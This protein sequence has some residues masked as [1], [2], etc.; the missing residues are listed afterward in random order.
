MRPQR[1]IT[2]SRRQ[3]AKPGGGIEAE[4][5]VMSDAKEPKPERPEDENP[6]WTQVREQHEWDALRAY[7]EA[8]FRAILQ[9]GGLNPDRMTEEEKM[10]FVDRAIHDYRREQSEKERAGKDTHFPPQ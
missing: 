10:D 5:S 1:A 4:N 6:E 7:G 3:E 9:A 8:R 2:L